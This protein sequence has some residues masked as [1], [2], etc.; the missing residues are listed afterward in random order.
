MES[1]SFD[2]TPKFTRFGVAKLLSVPKSR[3]DQLVR[4]A[5]NASPRKADLN[6]AGRKRAKKRKRQG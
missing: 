3:L 6:G 4:E 5:A 1:A 2:S